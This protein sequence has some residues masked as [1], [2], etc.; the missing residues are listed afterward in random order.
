[1]INATTDFRLTRRQK[2]AIEL[3]LKGTISQEQLAK[4]FKRNARQDVYRIIYSLMRHMVR[5]NKVDIKQ[6]LTDY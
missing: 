3:H 2:E 5:T 6:L 1:M 4:R